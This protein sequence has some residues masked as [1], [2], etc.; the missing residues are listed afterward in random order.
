MLDV[1]AAELLPTSCAPAP[2]V[3]AP[4][5]RLIVVS[6]TVTV[7]LESVTLVVMTTLP[8]SGLYSGAESPD[9]P[10]SVAVVPTC[11]PVLVLITVTCAVAPVS[12]VYG[13][14]VTTTARVP[15]G[16]SVS[17]RGWST[18]PGRVTAPIAVAVVG[19]TVAR[20]GTVSCTGIVVRLSP[21]SMVIF[22]LVGPPLAAASRAAWLGVKMKVRPASVQSLSVPVDGWLQP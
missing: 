14:S 13:E 7:P 20:I 22:V 1:P 8:P 17:F 5:L 12:T 19:P 16:L 15:S 3:A 18:D 11:F 2:A 10:A 21:T 6:L 4:V 9:R